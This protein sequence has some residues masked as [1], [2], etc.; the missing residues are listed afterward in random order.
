MGRRFGSFLGFC[1]IW[2]WAHALDALLCHLISETTMDC[3]GYVLTSHHYITVTSNCSGKGSMV[4]FAH[5]HR[6][7]VVF[8]GLQSSHE[9][10]KTGWRKGEQGGHIP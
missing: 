9:S 8:I 3:T 5:R 7:V 6:L 10:R 2:E 1:R 4:R